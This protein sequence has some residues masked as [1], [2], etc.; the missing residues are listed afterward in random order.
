MDK[1]FGS[2]WFVGAVSLAIAIILYLFVVNIESPG[3]KQND[4]NFTPG[5]SDETEQLKDIPVDIKIDK[6]KY[7]VTGVPKTVDVSLEGNA[8]VLRPTAIQKKLDLYVDLTNLDEGEHSVEINHGSL[9]KGLKA[10][11]EPKNVD[12][13]IEKRA[14]ESYHVNVD[15]INKDKLA[16]G[17]ELGEATIEPSTVSVTSSESVINQIALVKVLV[18]VKDVEKSIN[19][20]EVPVNVYDVQGNKLDV[21]I[22]PENV[23][24]SVDVS[25]PSKEVS[26]KVPTKGEVPEDYEVE[27]IKPDKDKLTVF[28]SNEDLRDIDEVKTEEVDLSKIK[29]S[30]K[31]DVSIDVPEDAE[32]KE[33]KVPVTVELK[34]KK[35]IK[36]AQV[37]VEN[38]PSGLTTTF[39]DGTNNPPKI[40]VEVEGDESD[41]KD[42]EASDLE[43]GIDLKGLKAGTH[44]V[45]VKVSAPDD[46]KAQAKDKNIT[47]ELS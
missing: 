14:T 23:M 25:N 19:K 5:G 12:V 43:A 22:E 33:E 41:V 34:Q 11:I 17:A 18:D 26:L 45:P 1:W 6:E 3:I 46:V 32:V 40:A 38:L 16:K 29:E 20:R 47:V 28:A 42:L 10:Y 36:D 21:Q 27:S 44:D 4:P 37:N 15:Y 35:T 2:K 24:V 39:S 31:V 8:S 7:V 30:G 9:P 13:T